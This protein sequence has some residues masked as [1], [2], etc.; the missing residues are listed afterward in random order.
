M[1]RIQKIDEINLQQGLPETRDGDLAGDVAE[2]VANVR[3]RGDKALR[4]YTLKF[5]GVQVE[6]FEVSD[7]EMD[8]ALNSVEKEFLQVLEEAKENICRFH[9]KQKRDDLIIFEEG[10]KILGQKHTPIERV[11][12]YVPGGTAVYPSTVLMTVIPAKI[13]GCAQI[14]IVSPPDRAGKISPLILAAAKIT[15]VSQVYKV[16]GAQAIAALA[17]GTQSVEKVFKIVGPGNRYV[18]EAKRQVSGAVGIDM[19]AGPSEILIIAEKNANPGFIA[20]DLLSQAEH[21]IYARPILLTDDQELAQA[22]RDQIEIRLPDLIREDIARKSIEEQG[23]IVICE[24]REQMFDLSNAIAPEHLEL[25]TADP[26]SDLGLVKNAGSVFLGEYTPEATGDYFS[27]TNHTLPTSGT[28]RFASPLS[29]DDFIKKTQ[30]SFYTREAL[31]RDAE[32][33][34]HF[35]RKEGLTAHAN[36]VKERIQ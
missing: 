3:E 17:Y 1:I 18:A 14:S 22:V 32:A 30:F 34:M 27:G 11:G 16:G 21:D 13:A 23:F 31:T 5:D 36:S 25:M 4:E 7:S 10:G 35:A 24:S 15:G 2:I 12:L 33:M 8:E 20:A 9:E 28:A 6:D 29:V 26:V 19:I